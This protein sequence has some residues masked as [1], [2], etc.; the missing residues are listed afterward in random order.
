MA[1]I[2]DE[3]TLGSITILRID[4]APNTGGGVTASIGS[5]A[6]LNNSGTGEAWI[7]QGSGNTNWNKVTTV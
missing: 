3:L 5:I 6:L 1:N 2:L 4:S 7:K